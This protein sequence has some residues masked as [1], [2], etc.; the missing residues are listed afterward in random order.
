[1]IPSHLYPKERVERHMRSIP[2]FMLPTT[3]EYEILHFQMVADNGGHHI[4][5]V[6]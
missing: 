2:Q 6:L 5:C 4:E 3:V 1:M